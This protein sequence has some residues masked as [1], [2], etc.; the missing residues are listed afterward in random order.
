MP[1][2]SPVRRRLLTYRASPAQMTGHGGC[3]PVWPDQGKGNKL[4]AAQPLNDILRQGMP[5]QWLM[6][7]Q[8]F[9]VYA[10]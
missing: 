2:L 10:D 6:F 5:V 4:D 9:C 8:V 7:P 1:Q 3:L